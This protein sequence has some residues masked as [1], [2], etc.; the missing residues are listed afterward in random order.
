M[1]ESKRFAVQ[2]HIP[3][4]NRVAVAS[5]RLIECFIDDLPV[6]HRA[7][8]AAIYGKNGGDLTRRFGSIAA[9]V[10][11]LP[12]TSA[13][14]DA[15]IVACNEAPNFYPLMHGVPSGC[16]AYCF[17]LL[18]IEGRSLTVAPLDER[19]NLLRR[20]LKRAGLDGLRLSEVFDDP[21]ALLATCEEH[22]LEG[23]VSKRRGD[24][25]R[26]GPNRGWI[27]VKRA[28]WRAANRERHKLFEKG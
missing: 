20:L 25:Y 12:V 14:T 26:S 28:A 21:A 8:V 3:S 19:R 5:E 24:R 10:E 16:W 9:A 22:G 4:S 11:R 17:D 15:E 23:I 13:I 1:S 27:K 6:R 7:R 2:A 18:E